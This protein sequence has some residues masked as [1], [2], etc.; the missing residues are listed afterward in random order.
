MNAIF[1]LDMYTI[2]L[3]VLASTF[4]FYLQF[5]KKMYIYV[6]IYKLWMKWD[7]V[8]MIE[9][10]PLDAENGALLF[11]GKAELLKQRL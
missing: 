3:A 8:D 1:L 4:I 6:F 5:E 2:L 11:E 9:L 10:C 7:Y